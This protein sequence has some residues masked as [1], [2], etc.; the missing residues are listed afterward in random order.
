MKT[1][2][3]IVKNTKKILKVDDFEKPCSTKFC[4]YLVEP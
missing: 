2:N 3:E 4:D 1:K